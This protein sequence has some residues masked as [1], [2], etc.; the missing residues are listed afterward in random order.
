MRSYMLCIFC[1]K[2][3]YVYKSYIGALSI[4][5]AAAPCHGIR[6]VPVSS[7]EVIMPHKSSVS[8]FGWDVYGLLH[9]CRHCVLQGTMLTCM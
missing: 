5:L 9:V 3:S 4:C 2:V 7:W 8:C 6:Q 1:T